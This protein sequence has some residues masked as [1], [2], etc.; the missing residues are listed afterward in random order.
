MEDFKTLIIVSLSSLAAYLSPISGVVFSVTLIFIVNFIIGYIAG[1]RVNHED[2]SFKK[3]FSCMKEAG[4]FFIIVV[5]TYT[6]GE[7][8]ENTTGALQSI[9]MITY[10][11]LYFYTTNVFKNLKK[12]FPRSMWIA[13]V[14]YMISFEFVKKVPG[15]EEFLKRKEDRL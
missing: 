15:L 14:Y 5:C 12:L 13:F 1:M 7:K 10:S 2:F 9:S 4:T 11:L 3:A 6:I 8:M